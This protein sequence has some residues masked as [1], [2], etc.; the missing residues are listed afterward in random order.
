[1]NDIASAD[2]SNSAHRI[3]M[4]AGA[5]EC[6]SMTDAQLDDWK[7]RGV[8]GFVCGLH[9]LS[10]MT[11]S[12][13]IDTEWEWTGDPAA[14]L[15]GPKYL[16]QRQLKAS[17][18]VRRSKE[19]RAYLVFYTLNR[20]NPQ[21]PLAE[22]FDDAGWANLVVPKVRDLAGAARSLGFTG[23]GVDQE[24]YP[25]GG[26]W[27]WNYAGGTHSEPEVRSAVRRRGTEFMQAVLQGFPGVELFAYGTKF[28][29]TWD[30]VVQAAYKG[31]PFTSWVQVDFWDGIT[32]VEGYKAIRFTTDVLYKKPFPAGDW[33]QAL[34]HAQ[35]SMQA[36]VSQH[37]SNWAYAAPRFFQSPAAW[38]D[39]GAGY[40]PSPVEVVATQ[41]GEF[42]RWG[43]GGEFY[44]YAYNKLSDFDYTPYAQTLKSASRPG[45]V[46]KN[47]PT[48]NVRAPPGTVSMATL[49][50][51]GTAKD[52]LA[53][54]SV[55]W[56]DVAGRRGAAKATWKADTGATEWSMAGIPLEAG[57]NTI[58][59][60]AENIKGLTAT[61]EV[62][63]ISTKPG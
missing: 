21:T 44:V 50:L 34:Q 60:T 16:L 3:V 10:G 9:N 19:F 54:R 63:V 23:I 59:I 45:I 33:T 41:L 43:T 47:P 4:W 42:R 1:V 11:A 51:E 29:E 37:W 20:N 55:S 27:V 30:A 2:E 35:S 18:L 24:I 57:V 31:A 13:D 8:A 32:S 52:D 14:D 38:I 36:Y 48:L 39:G 58:T 5:Q 15:S 56:A 7:D 17:A 61:R 26:S 12:N 53:V 46:D 49:D 6:A 22:W 25:G 28:P 40:E 62:S